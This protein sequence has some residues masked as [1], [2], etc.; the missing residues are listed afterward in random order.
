MREAQSFCVGAAMSFGGVPRSGEGT[1]AWLAARAREP[2]RMEQRRSNGSAQFLAPNVGVPSRYEALGRAT[3]RRRRQE[4]DNPQRSAPR[5]GVGRVGY[6]VNTAQEKV[7]DVRGWNNF[8]ASQKGLTT[9]I[10]RRVQTLV[11]WRNR[12]RASS[13]ES[14]P[15]KPRGVESLAQTAARL[16]NAVQPLRLET[17]QERLKSRLRKAQ[18][19]ADRLY[20]GLSAVADG[21][22][23]EQLRADALEAAEK[24]QGFRDALEGFSKKQA[25]LGLAQKGSPNSLSASAAGAAEGR[26]HPTGRSFP[27]MEGP[28]GQ[29]VAQVSP[30]PFPATLLVAS[31][32]H[33]QVHVTGLARL[34]PAHTVHAR[35]CGS[36]IDGNDCT[37]T[38][39]DHYHIRTVSVS[40]EP[41][42]ERGSDGR[43]ALLALLENPTGSGVDAFQRVMRQMTDTPEHDETQASL[44]VIPVHLTLADDVAVV[45]QGDG[46]SANV[47][48][49]YVIEESEIPICKLFAEDRELVIAFVDA[50]LASE[51]GPSA[52]AFTR[53]ALGSA[54]RADELALLDYSTDLHGAE[55]SVRGLFGVDAV[56]SAS[57]VLIGTGNTLHNKMHVERDRLALDGGLADLGRIKQLAVQVRAVQAAT[58]DS[59][60]ASLRDLS[61]TDEPGLL[62]VIIEYLMGAQASEQTT[63]THTAI[64]DAMD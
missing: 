43:A 60:A 19:A 13:L 31:P 23:P 37:L 54:G 11:S 57:A 28:G 24:V 9:E 50:V 42:M 51:G 29:V 4:T 27:L 15:A 32:S 12:T 56:K 52:N 55:S 34:F 5:S 6:G 45:Q 44:P 7:F 14:R 30:K 38:S 48:T 33:G 3:P 40:F 21:G 20:E 47:T 63:S 41:L 18:E 61:T 2:A 58:D 26:E 49:H 39:T 25:A 10:D 64:D 1:A 17:V 35:D 8:A 16:R 46:S 53:A 62:S 59:P 36:V 22:G